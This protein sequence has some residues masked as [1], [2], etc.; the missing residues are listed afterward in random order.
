MI[1]TD[2]AKRAEILRKAIRGKSPQEVID[3]GFELL[4]NPIYFQNTDGSVDFYSKAQINDAEWIKDIV[5]GGLE[6]IRLPDNHNNQQIF[7]ERFKEEKK[8]III[9]NKAGNLCVPIRFVNGY[10]GMLIIR[11][12]IWRP[13]DDLKSEYREWFHIIASIFEEK[14]T[15]AGTVY[16][17]RSK[18]DGILLRLLDGVEVPE[19]NIRLSIENSTW[20]PERYFHVFVIQMRPGNKGGADEIPEVIAWLTSNKKHHML[21]YR[22]KLIYIYTENVKFIDQTDEYKKFRDKLRSFGMVAGMSHVFENVSAI[23]RYYEQAENALRIG[24]RISRTN[25]AIMQF[26]D[27]YP[28]ILIDMW[29]KKNNVED[30]C[31]EEVSYL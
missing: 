6:V 21:R 19:K 9:D 8:P 13:D 16:K 10:V 24:F 28:H 31:S 12:I 1:I 20:K 5:E 15:N 22:S 7:I 2:C 30:L 18:Q 25:P 26:D 11:E 14:L 27:L 23:K 3:F 4:G 17:Q 29:G